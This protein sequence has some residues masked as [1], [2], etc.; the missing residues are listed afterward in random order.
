MFLFGSKIIKRKISHS[1]VTRIHISN[2]IY[3]AAR[4]KEEAVRP[5]GL[6]AGNYA[7][8][9]GICKRRAPPRKGDENNVVVAGTLHIFPLAQPGHVALSCVAR[10]RNTR[11]PLLERYVYI[12]VERGYERI[13]KD[14][15]SWNRC[16]LTV[17]GFFFFFFCM[18]WSIEFV[19][20]GM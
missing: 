14:V 6:K 3:T 7:E 16:V 9:S 18:F 11:I 19:F 8:K 2:A 5:I 20:G 1:R 10:I 15:S 12:Y 17:V 4:E 13:N